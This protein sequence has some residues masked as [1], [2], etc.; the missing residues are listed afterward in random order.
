MHLRMKKDQ[1]WRLQHFL[2]AFVEQTHPD[3]KKK[4]N[5]AT[6]RWG[7]FYDIKAQNCISKF[8]KFVTVT[9]CWFNLEWRCTTPFV[10]SQF[11]SV[12]LW[13]LLSCV[14][15]FVCFS[16]SLHMVTLNIWDLF[17]FYSLS[18]PGSSWLSHCSKSFLFLS[19]CFS[20]PDGLQ[21]QFL[22]FFSKTLAHI[23][24]FVD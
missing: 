18:S 9:C 20:E 13:G 14:C 22:F 8:L 19:C 7:D 5:V 21:V 17:F 12:F 23:F 1:T 11:C 15:C 16:S 3:K 4:K 10:F 6:S 2:L 24:I